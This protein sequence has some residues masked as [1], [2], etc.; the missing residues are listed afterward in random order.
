MQMWKNS[1]SIVII[2]KEGNVVVYMGERTDKVTNRKIQIPFVFESGSDSFWKVF[3]F[4]SV[5][6][7]TFIITFLTQLYDVNQKIRKLM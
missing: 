3:G 1:F 2:P 5:F 4:T 7:L 6:G